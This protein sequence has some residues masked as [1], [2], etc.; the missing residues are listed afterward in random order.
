MSQV[1]CNLDSFTILKNAYLSRY[2]EKQYVLDQKLCFNKNDSRINVVIGVRGRQAY[3]HTTLRYLQRSIEEAGLQKEIT[4]TICEH[5]IKPYY[6]YFCEDNNLN[7]G[8]INLNTS[9]TENMYSR[10]L[11]FNSVVKNFPST[12]WLLFH[13]C[14]LLVNCNFFTE[15]LPMMERSQTWIQPY[16]H[17]MVLN[18]KPEH[19]IL[20]QQPKSH[21]I[22]L[23][24]ELLPSVTQNLPGAVGGSILLRQNLFYNI[25]GYDDELFY[26]YAPEDALFWFKLECMFNVIQHH[27]SWYCHFGGAEYADKIN[28]YHQWHSHESSL[29]D[30]LKSMAEKRDLFFNL[31]YREIQELIAFKANLFEMAKIND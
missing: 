3:L 22:N 12:P 30:K 24:D 1:E 2:S 14:D 28:M 23:D 8:F 11:V 18:I 10:S 31:S 13:D 4:I 9:N 15:L 19:T 5:D 6:R 29:N 16:A 17:K 20:L 7:Y 21:I 25:G 27:K 26:G